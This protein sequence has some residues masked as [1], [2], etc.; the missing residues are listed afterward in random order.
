M[1]AKAAGA[2]PAAFVCEN[3][4]EEMACL[5]LHDK[6]LLDRPGSAMFYKLNERGR[7]AHDFYNRS[8]GWAT[9]PEGMAPGLFASEVHTRQEDDGR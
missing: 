4:N 1:L 6:G 5:R 3:R 9:G 8:D 2:F 7:A